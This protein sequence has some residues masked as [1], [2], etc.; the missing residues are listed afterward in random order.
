M[1][2]CRHK[3]HLFHT[4]LSY[5]LDKEDE[6]KMNTKTKMKTKK[7]SQQKKRK[8]KKKQSREPDSYTAQML[9]LLEIECTKDCNGKGG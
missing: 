9:E 5:T 2:T 7:N 4:V 8:R 1:P 3:Y 6:H